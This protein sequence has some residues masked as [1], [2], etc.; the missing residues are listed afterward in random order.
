MLSLTAKHFVI[1]TPDD[2]R[3]VRV[4]PPSWM[5]SVE[6]AL[7]QWARLAYFDHDHA[8]STRCEDRTALVELLDGLRD[9]GAGVDTAIHHSYYWALAKLSALG[10]SSSLSYT[11]W[12][13]LFPW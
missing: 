11:I 12:S 6:P 9:V 8:I 2:L 7:D 3:G 13:S 5:I 10:A 4:Y 1:G